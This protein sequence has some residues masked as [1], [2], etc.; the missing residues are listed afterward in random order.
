MISGRMADL[1]GIRIAVTRAAPQAED[2]AHPL[3]AAGADVVL[4][5]LIRIVPAEDTGPVRAAIG[6]LEEFDWIVF[7]S[8]NGV[9]LFADAVNQYGGSLGGARAA[10]A[11]VGPA[12][13][14]AAL[15]HGLETSVIPDEF[16]GHAI[17]DA[18]AGHGDVRGKRI[19]LARAGGARAELP[20]RLRGAGANV[21]D[22]ELYRAVPDEEGAMRLRS[23]IESEHVDLVTFT[24]ASTVLYFT[25]AV[26]TAGRARIAVIGPLTAD[27]AR[28]AGLSVHIEADPH[29][30]EGLV[31]AIIR[32]FREKDK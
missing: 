24:S 18:L 7:T 21:S 28:R 23:R 14:A 31:A 11:C 22:V 32:Y 2:L 15:R 19:L 10:I 30:S 20:D 6:R 26:G 5:P 1:D 25:Q 29:T 12:T 17:A 3:R 9:D 16:V 8:A 27:A 13:A 4:T